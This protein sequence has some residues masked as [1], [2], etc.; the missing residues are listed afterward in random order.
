MP[1]YSKDRAKAAKQLKTPSMQ[2]RGHNGIKLQ[3]GKL[4]SSNAKGSLGAVVVKA[5]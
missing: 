2:A 1:S 4:V 3:A 5:V